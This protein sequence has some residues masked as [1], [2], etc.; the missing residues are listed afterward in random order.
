MAS[1]AKISPCTIFFVMC[2][3][4]STVQMNTETRDQPEIQCDTESSQG[5]CGAVKYMLC[6]THNTCEKDHIAAKIK[7]I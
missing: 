2:E 1:E 7:Q 4:A 6:I 5:A 3:H